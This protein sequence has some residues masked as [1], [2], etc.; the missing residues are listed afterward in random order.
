MARTYKMRRTTLRMS[1]DGKR[2]PIGMVVHMT[3]AE[4]H[5]AIG[6]GQAVPL[7]K[8]PAVPRGNADKPADGEGAGT[9]GS[10]DEGK[11]AAAPQDA[12]TPASKPADTAS[13][14]AASGD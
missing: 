12:P 5:R 2:E 10:E 3:S 6:L 14:D 11:G 7:E 1:S 4:A 9:E 13:G 8:L